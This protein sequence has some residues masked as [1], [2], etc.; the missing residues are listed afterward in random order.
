MIIWLVTYKGIKY[1]KYLNIVSGIPLLVM[2]I[3]NSCSSSANPGH[4]A[5]E[6]SDKPNVIFVLADQWRAQEMG[7]AGN[8]KVKTQNLDQLSKES[9]VFNIAVAVMPVCSPF[10]ASL[11]WSH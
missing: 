5:K 9:V 11:L 1:L 4:L 2:I 8:K 10:W 7:Y 3:F 6:I